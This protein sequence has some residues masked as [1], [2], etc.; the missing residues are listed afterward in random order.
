[1]SERVDHADYDSGDEPCSLNYRS[2]V[3]G[4]MAGQFLGFFAFNSNKGF[5]Y[6]EVVS[7]II[8]LHYP[9]RG[10]ILST[11][12][13]TFY[14]FVLYLKT[15]KLDRVFDCLQDELKF[16]IVS[17][18][19]RQ[20]SLSRQIIWWNHARFSASWIVRDVQI[21]LLFIV[22]WVGSTARGAQLATHPYHRNGSYS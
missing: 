15:N 4:F 1:M 3:S 10:H 6:E 18:Q 2:F 16:I 13:H 17:G 5:H 12:S 8:S 21:W 14:K 7:G 19:R 20:N 9:I 22:I 11:R